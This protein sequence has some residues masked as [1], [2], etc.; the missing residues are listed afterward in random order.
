VEPVQNVSGFLDGLRELTASPTVKIRKNFDVVMEVVNT[1]WGRA[2]EEVRGLL[3]PSYPVD[4]MALYFTKREELF[5][6]L[7]VAV[8]RGWCVF[9]CAEDSVS[10]SPIPAEYGVEYWFLRKD[11]V[12]YR[13]ECMVVLDGFSPYHGALGEMCA[14]R[15][16]SCALA[17]A[18]FKVP[19]ERMYGAAMLALR[20]GEFE[21]MQ[22]CSSTY[23]KFSYY[24]DAE[25]KDFP[26][27]KPRVNMRDASHA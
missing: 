4:E 18:S 27:L 6:F 13:L 9:N 12:P 8:K 11:G 24:S 7:E 2:D 10:T 20:N 17:H 3:G 1:M 21:L 16:M 14:L 5:V 25:R 26:P 19:D 22:R 23:G 15:N